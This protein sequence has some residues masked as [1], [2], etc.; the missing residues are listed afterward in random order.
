MRQNGAPPIV[1]GAP[2]AG[3][4]IQLCARGDTICDGAQGGGP[5]FAHALYPVNGMVGEAATF[6]VGR[7]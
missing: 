3:K 7:L 4:T 2:Y 5:T 1:I 6:A